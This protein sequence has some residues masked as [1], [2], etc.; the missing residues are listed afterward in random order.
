MTG[1]TTLG[2]PYHRHTLLRQ[3]HVDGL[4]TYHDEDS[5]D[6]VYAVTTADSRSLTLSAAEVEPFCTGLL[7]GFRAAE[8]ERELDLALVAAEDAASGQCKYCGAPLSSTEAARCNV[9]GRS[10][11]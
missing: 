5:T 9:C 4:L 2:T 1:M 3:A 8:E 11:L 7:A 10:Q 6:D